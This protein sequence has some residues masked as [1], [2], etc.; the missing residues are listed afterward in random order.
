MTLLLE[1]PTDDSVEV[2]V[3]FMKESGQVLYP[4]PR[5][6]SRSRFRLLDVLDGMEGLHEGLQDAAGWLGM[7]RR[8]ARKEACVCVCRGVCVCGERAPRGAMP[9][10][11]AG[12]LAVQ[13]ALARC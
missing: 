2:A 13:S 8:R 12:A 5:V 6:P 4:S 10:P 11:F 9:T 3:N 7:W 1:N